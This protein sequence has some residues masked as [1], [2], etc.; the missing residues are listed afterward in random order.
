M[1]TIQIDVNRQI[2]GMTFSLAPASRRLVR[3][4]FPEAHPASALY[5]EFD[6]AAAFEIQHGSLLTHIYPA[7]IGASIA[8]IIA[9]VSQ[10]SFVDP[11]NG[12]TLNTLKPTLV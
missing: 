4:L 2:G 12:E 7:L 5:A 1:D 3:D 6:D 11:V 10:V 9:K 8:D